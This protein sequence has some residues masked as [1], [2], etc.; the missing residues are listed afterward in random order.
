[1][2][3][4]FGLLVALTGLFIVWLW[5][6]GRA[7]AIWQSLVSGTAV[8]SNGAQAS[9]APLSVNLTPASVFNSQPDN[10]LQITQ[11]W[12]ASQMPTIPNYIPTVG[13]GAF[14]IPTEQTNQ[15]LQ[16]TFP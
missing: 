14:N 8:S 5:A 4:V 2:R 11:P 3:S 13:S 7:N 6:T 16:M 9:P 1:M 10:I 12:I 15:P